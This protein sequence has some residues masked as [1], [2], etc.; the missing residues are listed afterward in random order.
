MVSGYTSYGSEG[1]YSGKF[2]VMQ[3]QQQQQGLSSLLVVLLSAP[4]FS[5]SRIISFLRFFFTKIS[6]P[7]SLSLSLSP[8][9]SFMISRSPVGTVRFVSFF[10]SED[11]P[12]MCLRRSRRPTAYTRTRQL[13]RTTRHIVSNS[14]LPLPTHRLASS[15]FF[16]L[17]IFETRHDALRVVYPTESEVQSGRAE[18]VSE[19]RQSM[20]IERRAF[21]NAHVHAYHRKK[22]RVN[23]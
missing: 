7:L 19:Q 3:Q 21:A 5:H 23:A 15:F 20:C 9:L 22:S 18:A 8:F 2:R 17:S 1:R 6:P 14:P 4:L 12:I 13:L 10:V 11:K 16:F